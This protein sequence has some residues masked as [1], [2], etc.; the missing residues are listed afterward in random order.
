MVGDSNFCFF[1]AVGRVLLKKY[2]A[3]LERWPPPFF[4]GALKVTIESSLRHSLVKKNVYRYEV[5]QHQ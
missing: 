3:T 1:F 2:T 5:A 4:C